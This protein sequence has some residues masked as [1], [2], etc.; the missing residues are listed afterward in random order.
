MWSLVTS[1]GQRLPIRS[2]PAVLGRAKSADI[3]LSHPSIEPQHAR[4]TLSSDGSLFLTVLEGAMVEVAGW[5]VDES[6]LI[7][8]DELLVGTVTLRLGDD[9]G[10]DELQLRRPP[11]SV[12]PPQAIPRTPR[13]HSVQPLHSR[14]SGGKTG[15]L[16][17]DLSQLAGGQKALL[18][19]GLLIV[20]AALVWALASLVPMVL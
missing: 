2:L 4:L 7:N 1:R 19:G 14:Q 16:H 13:R 9:S 18:I 15:L 3:V 6:V 12:Q 20:C 8:G 5:R 10:D 17:A 11:L